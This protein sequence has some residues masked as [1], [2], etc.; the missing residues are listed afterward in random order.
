MRRSTLRTLV[1]LGLALAL[2]ATS[3]EAQEKGKIG[4]KGVEMILKQEIVKLED[5][6]GHVLVMYES[7]RYDLNG[8][9]I[10]MINGVN[11]VIKGNGVTR[12]YFRF[13][14]ADGDMLLG[15]Y[16]GKVTTAASGGKPVTISEGTWSGTRG[17]G[18]WQNREATGTFKNQAV[19]D[20]VV[21]GNWEGTWEAKR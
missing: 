14:E 5:V 11:D 6:E 17:T 18:K 9:S 21:V 15:K 19:G 4:D 3:S 20:G 10:A 13:T 16:E 12:G 1:V 7:K 8:G 2:A